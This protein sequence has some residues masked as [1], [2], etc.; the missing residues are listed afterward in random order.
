MCIR[1]R[2]II[3]KILVTAFPI[4]ITR[5]IIYYYAFENSNYMKVILVLLVLMTLVMMIGNAVTSILEIINSFS[6]S[7]L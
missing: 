6:H 1:D 7:K 4:I 5:I 2:F 3:S